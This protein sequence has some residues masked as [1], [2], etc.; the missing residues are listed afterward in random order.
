MT[1]TYTE[2]V[3]HARD[4]AEDRVVELEAALERALAAL[5]KY[6]PILAD[7]IRDGVYKEGG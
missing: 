1:R 5:H 6:D 2:A 7:H 4:D 3:E